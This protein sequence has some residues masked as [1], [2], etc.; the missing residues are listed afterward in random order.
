M[1]DQF[2]V[3]VLVGVLLGWS[4]FGGELPARTALD[5]YVAKADP[6]YCW[7]LAKTIEK[8]GYTIFILDMKSQTWRSAS[9]VDRTLWQHWV[10]IVK[11]DKPKPGTGL[12]LIGHRNNDGEV[13]DFA[14]EIM[15]EIALGTNT[16]VAVV[17]QVPNQPLVFAGDN[18]RPR[19]EDDQ[20]AY[21]WDKFLNTGDPL[22]LSRFPMVKASVRAM[23][24]VQAFLKTDEGGGVVVDDFVVAGASKRGWTTY[25]TGAVDSRVKAIIPIVIDA[26]NL[27]ATLKHHKAIYGGWAPA[28]ENYEE[29]KILE[30]LDTPEFRALADLVDPYSYRH[31]LAMPKYIVNA[32]GD[33]LFVPDSSRFYFDDLQGEKLLCYVPNSDHYVDEKDLVHA[34]Y[35]AV[36]TGTPRPRFSW[37]AARPGEIVVTARDIPAE[38]TLW[39]ATNPEARDFRLATIGKAWHGSK[40]KADKDGRYVGRAALPDKGWTAF[41]VE[42]K[43]DLGARVPLVVTTD[44]HVVPDAYPGAGNVSKSTN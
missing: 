12:I 19:T 8:D 34:Y 17:G 18:K 7:E 11:P 40:V 36:L 33:Q 10:T 27:N 6:V 42:L 14:D 3:A 13:P 37:A 44:I 16:V 15:T 26:L 9:E 1:R 21:A 22:W 29:M 5:E 28:L 38:V 25:L 31:R 24:A 39:Q 41:F 32:S 4:A 23:D 35:H 30:R 43:Y 20:I 2:C